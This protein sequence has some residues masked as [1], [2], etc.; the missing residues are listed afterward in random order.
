M[1]GLFGGVFDP[2]HMGH[3]ALVRDAWERFDFDDFVVLVVATPGHKEWHAPAA[4]RKLLVEAAFPDA[5]IMLDLH[6]WTVDLLRDRAF[7]DPVFIIGA[8]EFASFPSWREPDRVLEL[9]RLAV[10]TRPGYPTE[11]FEAVLAEIGHP[12][13]VE[14][15]EIEPIELSS[16][17]IR[18]RVSR[19]E[20]IDG[21][22]P[23]EVLA[24]IDR[25]GLYR[26]DVPHR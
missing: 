10:A 9:A 17:E 23:S 16:T 1:T 19:G 18:A 24:E 7:D 14:F 5:R 11:R 8:D 13:R 26:E 21:L 12:E 15:F 20:S 2:P 3:V 4:I 6:S 25:R 22:V